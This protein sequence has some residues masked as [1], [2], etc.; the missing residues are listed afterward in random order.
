[1]LSIIN[2]S[3]QT[4][5]IVEALPKL[6]FGHRTKSDV[7]FKEHDMVFSTVSFPNIPVGTLGTIVFDY[8]NNKTYEVEFID[9]DKTIEVQTVSKHE[10]RK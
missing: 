1:L 10:I 4:V 6:S 3:V 8:G 2:V 5:D 9:H 7:Q